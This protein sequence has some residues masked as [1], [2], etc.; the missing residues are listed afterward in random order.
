MK[1]STPFL[2]ARRKF[3]RLCVSVLLHSREV[4]LPTRRGRRY[5]C[6]KVDDVE[7][8]GIKPMNHRETWSIEAW[9][10]TKRIAAM[11][12]YGEIIIFNRKAAEKATLSLQTLVPLETLADL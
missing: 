5:F 9:S 2:S 4:G 3:M 1:R 10:G 6:V 7:L 11:N 12:Q 8:S